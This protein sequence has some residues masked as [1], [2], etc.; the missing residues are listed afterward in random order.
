MFVK[1]NVLCHW[2]QSV[3]RVSLVSSPDEF[4]EQKRS[5]TA[6][7]SLSLSAAYAAQSRKDKERAR[8][9]PKHRFV[10]AVLGLFLLTMGT[11]NVFA[12]KLFFLDYRNLIVFSPFLI[13]VGLVCL[14]VALGR[15]IQRDLR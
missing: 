13:I 10:F 5:V 2:G 7:C 3:I 8:W 12:G 11:I 9:T 14:I 4:L 1:K 6:A 15:P